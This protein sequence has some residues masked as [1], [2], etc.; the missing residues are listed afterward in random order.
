[1][2]AGEAVAVEEYNPNIAHK[3]YRIPY[4]TIQ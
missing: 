3:F 2:I 4:L 1:M